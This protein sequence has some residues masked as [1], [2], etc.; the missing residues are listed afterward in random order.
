MK[1]LSFSGAATLSCAAMAVAA[2]VSPA[3]SASASNL[4]G[5]GSSASLADHVALRGRVV[6][7]SGNAVTGARVMLY[8]WPGTWPG[9]KVIKSGT[10]VPLRLV[11]QAVST[12]AGR[13]TIRVASAAELEASAIPG[14]VVNLQARV[15]GATDTS[16]FYPFSMRIVS[17]PAGAALTDLS[18]SST[19]PV[20]AT[21]IFHLSKS[22]TK[23]V[24]HPRDFWS[25]NGTLARQAAA[26]VGASAPTG[27]GDGQRRVR[28]WRPGV[29][30]CRG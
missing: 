1:R 15:A 29:R 25:E 13:Y 3:A 22:A 8:A 19:H 11:G 30:R 7:D 24:E 17:T 14:G 18:A 27:C 23:L 2:L 28:R 26:P 12:A 5:H 4:A 20:A 10:A 6:G 9:K 16:G 21:T